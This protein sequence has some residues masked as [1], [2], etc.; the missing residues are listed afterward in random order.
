MSMEKLIILLSKEGKSKC[1]TIFFDKWKISRIQG[2]I[3]L[4]DKVILDK[5]EYQLNR[6]QKYVMLCT[7]W[8]SFSLAIFTPRSSYIFY[9]IEMFERFWKYQINLII[10]ASILQYKVMSISKTPS[11]YDMNGFVYFAVIYQ[12]TQS[13]PRIIPSVFIIHARSNRCRIIKIK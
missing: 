2:I 12:N 10:L 1:M 11:K 4:H 3:L 7:E 13:S 9:Y 5:V 6:Q 8:T